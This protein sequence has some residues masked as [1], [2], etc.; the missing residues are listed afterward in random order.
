DGGEWL[1][2]VSAPRWVPIRSE[3]GRRARA[4]AYVVNR[5]NP[6]YA[7]RLDP[8]ATIALVLQ[9][10][11]ERGSCLDYLANTVSHMDQ[12]GIA[13]SALHDLLERVQHHLAATSPESGG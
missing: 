12:L 2:G 8:D 9:G 7:G 6:A 5:D 11:G 13:D 1:G 3:E 4:Y 10:I